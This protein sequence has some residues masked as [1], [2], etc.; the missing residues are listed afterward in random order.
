[1]AVA[2]SRIG[3]WQAAN[4]F[5]R[6]SRI[7]GTSLAQRSVASG[8]RVRNRQPLGGSIG[9]GISPR[10]RSAFCRSVPVTSSIDGIEETSSRV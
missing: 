10:P 7:C 9:E 3:W 8:Q 5:G 2:A 6:T 1:V 4:R